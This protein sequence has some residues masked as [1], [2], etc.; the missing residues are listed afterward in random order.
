MS[1]EEVCPMEETNVPEE[2]TSPKDQDEEPSDES[3][4]PGDREENEPEPSGK[5][6]SIFTS[7]KE[8]LALLYLL[9][10]NKEA[11]K[12][13]EKESPL[14]QA[15]WAKSPV[16][17][18]KALVDAIPDEEVDK[19]GPWGLTPLESIFKT[20]QKIEYSHEVAQMLLDR[21]AKTIKNGNR[22]GPKT[23][24]LIR[25]S[26]LIVLMNN[27]MVLAKKFWEA[28]VAQLGL[29]EASKRVC[30]G[31]YF[32]QL[33]KKKCPESFMALLSWI[34]DPFMP[35]TER[36]S[37]FPPEDIETDRFVFV[38]YLAACRPRIFARAVNLLLRNHSKQTVVEKLGL[39]E[40]VSGKPEQGILLRFM[41]GF[42]DQKRRKH[43]PM[44]FEVLT[45]KLSIPIPEDYM[46]QCI[47]ENFDEMVYF[48]VFEKGMK[49]SLPLPEDIQKKVQSNVPLRTFL[50][51]F[52]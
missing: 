37:E 23:N 28:G 48:L 41:L 12:T 5:S 16:S 45:E 38:A 8:T 21:G 13:P 19:E 30:E 32:V 35:F 40:N 6:S 46:N 24:S 31:G 42:S 2:P 51:Q 27:D 26:A 7:L 9:S 49:P 14:I 11:S 36:A 29:E 4:S 25:D 1:Q 22:P 47:K 10:K 18:I 15:I 33:A 34:Q 43:I 52:Q 20:R 3:S 50:A 17:V 39:L 44:L